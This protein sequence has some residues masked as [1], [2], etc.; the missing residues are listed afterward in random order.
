VSTIAENF[1]VSL[2][3]QLHDDN[4]EELDSSEGQEPL[5]YLHGAGNIVP[6]L[7]KVL[8]GKKVGDKLKVVVEP[9]DGYG[10]YDDE[11]VQLVPRDK[12]PENA[13]LEAG[14]EI[15]AVNEDDEEVPVLIAE[16]NEKEVTLDFNHP[17]AGVRLHFEV[18]VVAIRKA[19]EEEITHGHP[20]DPENPHHH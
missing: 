1:V 11:A 18:E 7:E 16:V 9:E 3:Y 2:H 12:F 20:H 13:Q 17:L 14:M 6:G 5:L 10:E 19:T 4:G 15:V 8:E